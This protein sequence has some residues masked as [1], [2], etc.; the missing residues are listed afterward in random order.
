MIR[1][2]RTCFI[3][4]LST[5]LLLAVGPGAMAQRAL[6]LP[7]FDDFSTAKRGLDPTLW[8]AGGGTYVNNTLPIN[9]PSVNVVTFDGLNASGLP[10]VFL[11]Q[12]AYGPTDTL[13]SQPINLAGLSADSAV[14]LSFYWQAR[15]LGELPD[16]GD[17]LR[18]QFQDNA[19]GWQTVWKQDGG[20][21]NN[22]FTQVI[23]SIS[24]PRHLHGAFRF[25]FQSFGRES[26]PYDTWHI[27]YVY[28]NKKRPPQDRFINDVT[29]RQQ[30]GPYLKRYTAMP[31]AQYRLNPAA[32]TADSIRTDINNL[33]NNFDNTTPGFQITNQ[34][35]G[36]IVQNQTGSAGQIQALSSLRVAVRPTPFT[37]ADGSRAVLQYGFSIKTTDDRNPLI[38]TL[39]L[40]RNDTL[41]ATVVLDDYYAYDD[42][43][44]DYAVQ[45]GPRERVAVR[46]IGRKPDVIQGIRACL[47]PFNSDQSLAG[48]TVLFALYDADRQGRPGKVI[49]QKSFPITYPTARNGF[50]EFKFE[51]GIA[52]ADTFFIGWQQISSDPTATVRVGFDKNSLFGSQIFYSATTTWE[53][54]LQSASLNLAGAIML[55]PVMGGVATPIVTAIEE[56][57]PTG[58]WLIYPNP[59][60]GLIR[61]DGPGPAQIDVFDLGGRLRQTLR[62]A[63]GQQ[64]ADL[65][66]L[67]TGLYLLRL[68]DD[69]RSI[70]RKILRQ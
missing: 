51:R 45:A 26:G 31:L 3:F 4:W 70:T 12:F 41:S 9:H 61:W 48:Q 43:E 20:R 35:S 28:L 8:Q 6:S 7:F 46:F 36:K 37:D 10:Y 62:P 42:G 60:T 1:F 17:S 16:P 58:N 44:A 2:L 65:G 24:Q 40:T 14:S 59:T 34:V 22:N 5:G 66:S 11:N 55:R 52:V 68:S 38:P 53:Q 13:T 47:V 56:E 49:F 27:D 50:A 63:P 29:I 18:L 54:N 67:P 15:G 25:R 23:L 21:V 39:D 19:G 69:R 33:K 30:P 64:S 32:E 57:K